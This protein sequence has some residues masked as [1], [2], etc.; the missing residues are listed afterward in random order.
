ML[1]S[2]P[3]G[4]ALTLVR[5]PDGVIVNL[6][7]DLFCSAEV[8]TGADNREHG[9]AWVRAGGETSLVDTGIGLERFREVAEA[10]GLELIPATRGNR[11]ALINPLK[12]VAMEDSF[13]PRGTWSVYIEGDPA[14]FNVHGEA[15]ASFPIQDAGDIA[16]YGADHAPVSEPLSPPGEPLPANAS[17]PHR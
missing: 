1:T 10:V 7:P 6:S 8:G 3:N 14:A 12:I 11:H 15:L 16:A 9:P 17:A 2:A 13:H 4:S 5:F